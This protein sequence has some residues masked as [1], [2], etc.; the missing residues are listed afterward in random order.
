[1]PVPD[2]PRRWTT[3]RATAPADSARAA[4]VAIGRS[5]LAQRASARR[6]AGRSLAAISSAPS[7]ALIWAHR[8]GRRLDRGQLDQGVA[9][10]RVLIGQRTRRMLA[11]FR[12]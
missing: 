1:V 11:M 10:T 3:P 5:P 2:E 4:G 9:Q 6:Q 7:R 12:K 8:A